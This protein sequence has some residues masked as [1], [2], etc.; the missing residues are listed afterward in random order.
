MRGILRAHGAGVEI[1]SQ[2]GKGT[3]IKLYF[4][5]APTHVHGHEKAE[6]KTTIG[7]AL[8]GTLLLAEDEITLREIGREM[9]ER[10][11][12]SVVEAADG[13]EAWEHFRRDPSRFR[14]VVLDLTMPRRGGL[15]VYALIRN[16]AP[17]LPIVLCSGYSREEIPEPRDSEEPR[18]F[19]QKPFTFRQFEAALREVLGLQS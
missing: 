6:E 3:R 9:A 7:A 19:L 4:P 8:S 1:H 17:A 12:F 10:L 18:V 11:G 13:E 5:A 14:A 15:E 16:E 2:P